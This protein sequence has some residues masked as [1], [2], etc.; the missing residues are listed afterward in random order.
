MNRHPVSAMNAPMDMRTPLN[1]VC[2]PYAGGSAAVYREWAAR[3]PD[4]I[5]LVTPHL[6][7]RGLRNQ[8]APVY[9]WEDLLDWLVDDMQ[10]LLKQPFAI[11]GHSMGALIGIELAQALRT[12]HGVEPVWFGASACTAPSQRERELHWLTCAEDTF[13]AEVRAL[14]GMPE[15]LLA[16]RDF[17][18]LVLPVLRA[19]FHLCGSY[20]YRARAPLN[21]P[22]LA[23]QGTT[24]KISQKPLNVSAWSRET[25]G[26]FLLRSIEAG[27]FFIN[28]H[29][30]AVIDLISSSLYD[31]VSSGRR[32]SPVQLQLAV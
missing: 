20:E 5:N 1:L 16:N 14:N 3:L 30:E 32:S 21:C 19:D 10:P 8:I 22:L 29:R 18:D 7:G 15:E 25:S 23:I 13:L 28:T 12:R 31:V 11:F 24:D 4:W 26:S 2:L 9:R 17:M 6:P 27:H